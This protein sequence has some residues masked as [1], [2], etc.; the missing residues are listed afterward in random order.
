M[1]HSAGDSD[2]ESGATS[3][4]QATGPAT[5]LRQEGLSVVGLVAVGLHLLC[6]TES[7]VLPLRVESGVWVIY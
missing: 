6:R 2:S 1:G 3:A 4:P 5:G 7:L